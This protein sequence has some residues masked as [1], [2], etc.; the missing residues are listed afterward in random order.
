MKSKE[1]KA[2]E[3]SAENQDP[4]RPKDQAC[5]TSLLNWV[6]MQLLWESQM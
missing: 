3:N 2:V 4:S 6:S 5:Q 1:R